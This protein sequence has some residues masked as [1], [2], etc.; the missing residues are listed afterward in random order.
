L[1]IRPAGPDDAEVLWRIIEPT[2]RAGET[3]PLAPD[4]AR[5]E[6]LAYWFSPGHT[7][8]V[9]EAAAPEADEQAEA[10]GTY[11]L[12]ANGRGGGAHVANCG[13]MTAPHA[14]GRGVGRAMCT[15]ALEFARAAGYLAMQFNFVVATN[16]RAVALWQTCGFTIV[17]RPP[18]A[19]LHPRLGRVD[20]FVM[21]R[22]L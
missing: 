17:G 11:Y 16:E 13:F 6:A 12:R 20:A 7:V 3:Y 15:H 9:A 14:A 18:G 10:V 22:E 19:F 8:F 5:S 2:L 21:Y 1:R 4:W